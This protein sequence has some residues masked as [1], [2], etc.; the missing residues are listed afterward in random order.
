MCGRIGKASMK[1][2]L[3]GA[4]EPSGTKDAVLSPL[5]AA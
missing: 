4:A 3:R 1:A 5:R 2:M